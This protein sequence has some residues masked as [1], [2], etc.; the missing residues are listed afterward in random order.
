MFNIYL[1]GAVTMAAVQWLIEGHIAIGVS[2]I[3]LALLNILAGAS[4]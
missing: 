4:Q 3:A 2:F 1:A